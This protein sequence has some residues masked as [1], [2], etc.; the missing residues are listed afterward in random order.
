[1]L[2]YVLQVSSP[3]LIFSLVCCVTAVPAAAKS[4]NSRRLVAA[5]PSECDP[6]W[7]DDGVCQPECDNFACNLDAGDCDHGDKFIKPKF[8]ECPPSCPLSYIGD[9]WCDVECNVSACGRD[10]GDCQ[11]GCAPGCKN[12]WK[13]DGYCDEA[14]DNKICN[15]DGGDCDHK[16]LDLPN[17]A[18]CPYTCPLS[19]VADGFCDE[20]CDKSECLFDGSDCGEEPPPKTRCATGCDPL[21]L[22]DGYCDWECNSES[23]EFDKGDCPTLPAACRAAASD[24]GPL[25]LGDGEC[26]PECNWQ[27]CEYDKGDCKQEKQLTRCESF[28]KDCEAPWRGDGECD[29]E[30]NNADCEYD[31]G[32]CPSVV[33]P[34][35]KENNPE[36][37]LEYLGDRVC[38]D[39]CSSE[40]CSWDWNDCE[41]LPAS[42]AQSAVEC[43]ASWL[44]DG[45]C[46]PECFTKGCSYD[47]GDCQEPAPC[48]TVGKEGVG[49]GAHCVFPFRYRGVLYDSCT[50]TNNDFAWCSTQIS[51]RGEHVK[52][53]WGKCASSCQTTCLT[54]GTAGV[55][56]GF[57]CEFPFVYAGQK[58]DSCTAVENTVPWC[59]TSTGDDYG[60]QQGQFGE[61]SENCN[62]FSAAQLS[63]KERKNSMA[64]FPV[65]VIMAAILLGLGCTVV[66]MSRRIKQLGVGNAARSEYAQKIG[67]TAHDAESGPPAKVD[68]AS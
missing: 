47:S 40:A 33:P 35:C 64:M 20:E 41:P 3:Q 32:D 24:C 22:G 61:C 14:C 13:G 39:E 44:G 6:A 8:Q 31:G 5:C 21:W 2:M 9:E 16:N 37:L 10:M 57:K 58:Y 27:E 42:C 48:N 1:M 54:T 50:T 25:W 59:S 4:S 49:E 23:C 53:Q 7:L 43:R 28:Q 30:C 34:A 26:D 55:G 36:C 38:D 63:I 62:G 29:P 60:Y 65:I 68:V 18:S 66:Y 46:D 11:P 56:A 12:K 45:E 17:L 15:Y 67:S 52:D 19:W 51:S